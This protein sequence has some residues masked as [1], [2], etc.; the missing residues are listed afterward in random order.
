MSVHNTIVY[1]DRM[2]IMQDNVTIIGD[3]N[4]ISGIGVTVEG[5]HNSIRSTRATVTGNRNKVT[6]PENII[7]GQFNKIFGNNN[8]VYGIPAYIRG[9]NNLVYAPGT[10]IFPPDEPTAQEPQFLVKTR[11]AYHTI[12]RTSPFPTDRAIITSRYGHLPAASSS[13][14]C[15]TAM[16]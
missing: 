3:Y 1:A 4:H 6:G 2:T 12:L 10:P 7:H 14:K 11:F 13:V 9:K 8:T 16:E 5:H 15:S